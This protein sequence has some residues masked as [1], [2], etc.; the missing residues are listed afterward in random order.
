MGGEEGE[1]GSKFKHCYG[2]AMTRR[3]EMQ[4]I[5]YRWMEHSRVNDPCW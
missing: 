4:D 2:M 1:S 5:Q 3:E